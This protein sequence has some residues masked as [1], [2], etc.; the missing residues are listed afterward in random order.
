MARVHP[1]HDRLPPAQPRLGARLS[2]G[3]RD[4]RAHRSYRRERDGRCVEAGSC[5]TPVNSPSRTRDPYYDDGA[6]V[7]HPVI[8]VSWHQAK[9]YC[10]WS[11]ARLPTEAEWEYA[12]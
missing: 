1:A 11:G 7:D 2:P 4:G 9:D 12:A 10:E 3:T 8:C 5:D 6:Y